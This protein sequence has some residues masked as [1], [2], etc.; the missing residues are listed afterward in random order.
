MKICIIV[1]EYPPDRIAGTA[2]VTQA[3]AKI[4]VKNDFKVS[5]VVT[6][7]SS[8][9]ASVSDD[10]GARVYRLETGKIPYLRW[11]VRL[12]RIRAVVK[13]INPDV[14]HAQAISCGL[15]ARFARGRR[16]LPVLTSIQGRDLY[17]ASLFQKKTEVRW[18]L[19]G[20]DKLITVNRDLA[21]LGQK[22]SGG[23]PVQVIHNGFTPESIDSDRRSL[24]MKYSVSPEEFVIICIARLIKAKG[25]DIL[26]KAL[27]SVPWAT[28]WIVG[29]GEERGRLEWTI[30]DLGLSNRVRLLGTIDHHSVAERLK[31][32]DLFV[33][34]SRSEPFGISILEAMN[35]GLPIIATPVGGIPEL[36]SE[37]NGLL[38]RPES[39]SA[40]SEAIQTMYEDSERR[41]Q[42][43]KSNMKKAAQY[44]WETICRQYI[45]I[46]EDLVERIHGR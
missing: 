1:N 30:S 42:I 34:P 17:E 4:L 20:A 24:R 22:L 40:L 39:P 16:N 46:Y 25:I 26:L 8:G 29:D 33:L 10:N 14:I 44:H 37:P 23:A 11:L 12:F 19:S 27:P 43:S 9:Y 41:S 6:E 21:Y 36:V 18:A 45:Q 38:V 35:A 5:I 7:R 28:V 15:Y 3:I 2:M 32:A 31:A 13:K